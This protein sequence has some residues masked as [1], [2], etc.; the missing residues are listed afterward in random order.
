MKKVW[1]FGQQFELPD[2]PYLRADGTEV[3]ERYIEPIHAPPGWTE[4][5]DTAKQGIDADLEEKARRALV[6]A[7]VRRLL[8]ARGIKIS[9][10]ACG[11]C[12]GVS[13]SLEVDGEL[14]ADQEDSWNFDMFD[15]EEETH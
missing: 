9:T 15:G 8:A 3:P 7:R 6:E 4:A 2:P 1:R 13:F 12:D 10:S 5:S 14:V 11:C